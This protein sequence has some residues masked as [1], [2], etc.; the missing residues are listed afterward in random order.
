MKNPRTLGQRSHRSKFAFTINLLKP[1][2]A[3]LRTGWKLYAQN[4]S[5]FN[6]A[7]S[8]TFANVITGDYPDYG[9]DPSKVLISRG[10]LTPAANATATV[11]DGN[12]EIIW[13]DN[14]EV[15]TAKPTDKTLIAIL[16]RSENGAITDSAGTER[17][18]GIQT[19]ALPANW[20]GDKVHVYLGF[21]SEDGREVAS[22]VYLGSITIT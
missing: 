20:S 15:N 13:D 11:A 3:L 2:T 19:L 12:I 22:S 18:T 17:M 9:I 4:K 14:S 21:I 10:P 7:I 8:Y 5:A 16:N 6:A 1:M